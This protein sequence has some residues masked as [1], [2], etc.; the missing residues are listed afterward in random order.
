MNTRTFPNIIVIALIDNT[1]DELSILVLLAAAGIHCIVF[2]HSHPSTP[3]N[4]SSINPVSLPILNLTTNLVVTNGYPPVT[5]R[6]V[7]TF[8]I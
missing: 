3:L 5:T 1:L 4:P 7:V 8:I 6:L 2:I